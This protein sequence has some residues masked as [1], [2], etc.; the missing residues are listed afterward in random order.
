LQELFSTFD[1]SAIV[2]R[3]GP[4]AVSTKEKLWDKWRFTTVSKRIQSVYPLDAYFYASLGHVCDRLDEFKLVG[5]QENSAR[6]I[7]VPKDSRGPRLISCEPLEYQWVQQGLG[8]AIMH[9]VEHHPLTR[10]NV[11]FSDQS[12]NQC[13]ALLGSATGRYATLDLKEASDRVSLGLVRL[14]FPSGIIKYL[15]NCRSL[16]TR[17]PTGEVLNL[18]KFAPMGSALCFPILALTT[19]ALLAARAEDA[20]TR[21]GILVYGDDVVVPTAFAADAIEQLETF[22]LLVNRAKSC[23][24]GF[25][26]ESCGVDAYK[27]HNITPLRL[28][29]GLPSRRQVGLYPSSIAFANALY[30][31]GF[32]S[33]FEYVREL[34]HHEYGNVPS[35][36][37]ELSVPSLREVEPENRPY[38]W[39]INHA[40]QKKEWYVKAVESRPIRKTI[41]GWSM[42][43]RCFTEG[44]LASAEL[45]TPI[46][47]EQIR[48]LLTS[49]WHDY[50]PD[51]P[52][53]ADSYTRRDSIRVTNRWR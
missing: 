49:D 12:P 3:H 9:H 51:C 22:G 46:E 17:L 21:D 37:M 33:A 27:G 11:H 42:L 20:D 35:D 28:R 30:D 52:F 26:R 8:R 29:K 16:S 48:R 14:L 18:R 6:V 40:L 5:D 19:W 31:R 2:P 32:F 25:F 39:R 45:D 50:A 24:T 43:L 44:G 15:E 1:P 41:D 10:Y 4:G 34:I 36:D 13:G 38:K 47:H 7:L 23:V 53:G